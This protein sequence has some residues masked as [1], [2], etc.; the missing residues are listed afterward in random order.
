MAPEEAILKDYIRLFNQGKFHES[1]DV[2][3]PL[4]KKSSGPTKRFYQGLIQA[5]V[6]LHHVETKNKVGAIRLYER[7]REKLKGLP[8]EWE[9][10]HLKKFLVYLRKRI[11]SDEKKNRGDSRMRIPMATEGK[12]GRPNGLP[13]RRVS[14]P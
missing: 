14:R 1:H 8:S 5:S 12:K 9:G 3:E 11:I 13:K 7:A 2:L 6:A 10:I 4:W